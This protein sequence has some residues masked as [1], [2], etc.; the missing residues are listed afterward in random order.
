VSSYLIS[1]LRNLMLFLFQ[2]SISIWFKTATSSTLAQ[3]SY[4]YI[5]LKFSM[6]LYSQD[7]DIQMFS[8]ATDWPQNQLIIQFCKSV[9]IPG[10]FI[11]QPYTH[12]TIKSAH[13][14]V[15]PSPQKRKKKHLANRKFPWKQTPWNSHRPTPGGAVHRPDGTTNITSLH[16]TLKK[17]PFSQF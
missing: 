14:M 12:K 10:I 16:R 4:H 9:Y 8:D 6:T 7:P 3:Q 1:V 17:K 5:A 13:V 11:F 15:M 2:K